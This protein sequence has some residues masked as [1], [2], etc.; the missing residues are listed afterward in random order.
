LDFLGKTRLIFTGFCAK[1]TQFS[2]GQ[3]ERKLGFEKGLRKNFR[4]RR[5]RKAKPNKA[6]LHPSLK[7]P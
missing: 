7:E 1:Q 2:S 6:D 4:L 5:F 3:N